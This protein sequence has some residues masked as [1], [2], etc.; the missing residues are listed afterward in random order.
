MGRVTH[1][2]HPKAILFDLDR[3]LI[4]SRRAWC[5][6]IEESVLATCG[7]RVVAEPLL[8]EYH[9]RPL[10]H[11][12]SIIVPDRQRLPACVDLCSRILDRSA[13]KRLL[14]FDGVAMALD[15]MR[16]TTV[17]VGVVSRHPHRLAR[18]HIE[19]TGL[20]R[21]LAVLAAA[22]G[23]RWNLDAQLRQCCD[24]LEVDASR[25]LYVGLSEH[26]STARALG[27]DALCAGWAEAEPAAGEAALATP[28]DLG[29]LIGAAS[30]R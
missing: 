17:E 24:F 18:L 4:D 20:D 6:A 11:A 26:T 10:R 25:V 2:G 30:S 15:A 1:G 23:G 12:L 29:R 13:L 19:S 8:A 22:P 14:V 16:D 7:E 27:F 5:Y 3:V 9:S 21:F 28:A